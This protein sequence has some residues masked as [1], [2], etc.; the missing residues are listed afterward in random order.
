MKNEQAISKILC[1]SRDPKELRRLASRKEEIHQKLQC[2]FYQLR[3]G[4]RESISTLSDHKI[5][6]AIVS[7]RPKNIIKE[8]IKYT[9]FEDSFDVIVTAEDL[10]RGKP[11]PEMF[12][13]AARLNMIP[14]RCIVFGNSNSSVEA[15]HFCLDEACGSC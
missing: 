10:H 14:D 9:G 2:G 7:T 8:A 6:I 3:E 4:S 13:F 12:V 15:A 1:W 5:P 11:H